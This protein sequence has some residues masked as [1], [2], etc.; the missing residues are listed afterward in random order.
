MKK[1][2]HLSG[3]TI[4]ELLI[5]LAI[6]L[7]LV[8]VLMRV[9]SETLRMYGYLSRSKDAFAEA[10]TAFDDMTRMLAR[11][12]LNIYWGYQ[13][14]SGN[15]VTSYG[16]QS[17]LHFA[18]REGGIFPTIPGAEV[19]YTSRIVFEAPLGL[20]AD[21]ANKNL[22]ALLNS[23]GFFVA[24]GTDPDLI[25]IPAMGASNPRRYRLYRWLQ[26][27]ESLP[28][29]ETT[30]GNPAATGFGWVKPAPGSIRPVANNVIAL[31]VSAK[32]G[33]ADVAEYDTRG[34]IAAQ[35]HQLPTSVKL[36]IV[37]IDETSAY[38]LGNSPTPPIDIPDS[39]LANPDEIEQR[40][41]AF[42][43]S[44]SLPGPGRPPLRCRVFSADIPL[45]GARWSE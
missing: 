5:A 24:Y 11:S 36:V 25:G 4:I 12:G 26:P 19:P 10:R 39:I 3:F 9:T 43:D 34:A 23:C 13:F 15:K 44:L 16:R 6:S 42:C 45:V 18:F 28:V 38:A 17:E 31:F 35:K 8:L 14:D 27:A 22:Q 21:A 41:Q 37:A 32:S 1:T 30:S 29:Y 40:A 7:V 20:H 33:A 2:K